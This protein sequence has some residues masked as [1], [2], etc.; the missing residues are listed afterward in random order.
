MRHPRMSTSPCSLKQ[1]V[2]S[3][4]P[5]TATSMLRPFFV[6]LAPLRRKRSH[7]I[8]LFLWICSAILTWM[9]ASTS[10]LQKCITSFQTLEWYGVIVAILSY[11]YHILRPNILYTLNS[12]VLKW[13][14]DVT[15]LT[16]VWRQRRW[17][18]HVRWVRRDCGWSWVSWQ[19]RRYWFTN[20]QHR[21]TGY[22]E[23][24]RCVSVEALTNMIHLSL[25]HILTRYYTSRAY[26][27]FIP[28]QNCYG[29][30][31][32]GVQ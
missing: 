16:Y 27:W 29:F 32:C 23:V 19:L 25:F 17:P 7:W 20:I 30:V 26:G 22:N 9:R 18:Y 6:W 12:L 15:A 31:V 14:W 13:R 3:M 8:R 10:R 1:K 5:M 2:W 11:W 24:D 28:L 21:M 4:M